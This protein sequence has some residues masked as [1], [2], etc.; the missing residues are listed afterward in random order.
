MKMNS[1]SQLDRLGRNLGVVCAMAAS[2]AIGNALASDTSCH[3]FV[4]AGC[5]VGTPLS[6]A[7]DLFPSAQLEPQTD[8][9]V[10]MTVEVRDALMGADLGTGKLRVVFDQKSTAREVWFLAD[11]NR[12]EEDLLNAVKKIWG[13]SVEI[14]HYHYPGKGGR[15]RIY[16]MNA[17]W[18]TS[19]AIKAKLNVVVEE[20]S[21]RKSVAVGLVREK[22]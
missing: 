3:A 13:D 10:V 22:K 16:A 8:G 1:F 5:S 11:S 20:K 7:K 21:A 15:P 4:L 17:S 14:H 19:C 9:T 6:A 12:T 18:G 2:L